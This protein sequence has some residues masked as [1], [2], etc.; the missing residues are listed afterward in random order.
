[1]LGV[2]TKLDGLIDRL[3]VSPRFFRFCVVGTSGMLVSFVSLWLLNWALPSSWGAWEHRSALAGSIAI[4]IFSNFLLNYT[5]T[6]ADTD[7]ASSAAGWL[8]K[9]AR[10]YMV[11]AVAA[12]VQYVV[13]LLVFELTPLNAWLLLLIER[14]A[15]ASALIN[16]PGLYIATGIGIGTAMFINYFANHLWTFKDEASGSP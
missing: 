10:F 5:W 1:M 9:L 6:W 2:I 13:A 15:G 8:A 12:S 7:R 4:A 11:S 3:P 16:E 14:I